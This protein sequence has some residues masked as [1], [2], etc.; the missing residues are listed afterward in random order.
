[1]QPASPQVPVAVHVT[2]PDG[3]Y[4]ASQVNV[5]ASP[6]GVS[7]VLAGVVLWRFGVVKMAHAVT[8]KVI[9]KTMKCAALDKRIWT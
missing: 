1:M 6:T 7:V 9:Q 8:N 3:V 2:L 5:M 4:P